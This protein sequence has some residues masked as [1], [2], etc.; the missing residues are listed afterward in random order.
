MSDSNKPAALV[1]RSVT[2]D[3]SDSGVRIQAPFH[4][5]FFAAIKTQ[6]PHTYRRW[7]SDLQVIAVAYPYAD[8]AEKIAEQFFSVEHGETDAN[9]FV[10]RFWR[11]PSRAQSVSG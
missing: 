2:V 4:P 6:V 5:A 3:A 11:A 8:T 9:F 7:M 1:S 10:E